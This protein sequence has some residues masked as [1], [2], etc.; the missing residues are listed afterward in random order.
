[1]VNVDGRTGPLAGVRVVD[2]TA[3]VM[4]PYCTQIMADMGADVIKVEPPEGDNTRYIS[5]GPEPSMSGVFVNVNRGKR[6]ITLDLQSQAGKSALRA[7]V[8]TA[9]VFIHSMRSKAITQ[10]GFGYTDVAEINPAIVYTNCYGYG[11]RGPYRDRPAY[12]D[13][14]QAECGLPAVQEQL[15]GE[16]SYVGTIM[17]DKVAGLTAL[18]ATMMA[19]F[20][21][22][23]TGEGQEV[24]VAMFETMASFMLVEHANGAMFDPPLG[25][26]VYPRTVAP[27]RRPYRTS[28]GY[29]AALI[30][31]DKH[32]AAFIDA[33]QPAWATS[34]HARLEQRARDIDT[35]YALLAE[36]LQERTTDEWLKL[37]RE[38]DI[39][40]APLSTPAEL[41]DNPH[42]NAAGFF[43][44]V[45]TPH[46]PVRFPGVP[47]WFSRSPGRVTGS[48]PQLGADTAEVLAELGRAEVPPA[49]A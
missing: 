5:V 20:H 10:L 22:E 27:N 37:F 8:E 16:A 35:I 2:L 23:R 1:M 30:Y 17:A 12:D 13:T 49:R 32:W 9:D 29:I 42:L 28:D 41:F 4:G 44:T 45:D 48:A 33:V 34:Q 18:Y 21:R 3:M 43:E 26:A 7:L 31:N 40:A 24:E 46:G 6:S 25:P 14:I 38:L 39:P 15:T 11:R 19:L 36:T 47:T